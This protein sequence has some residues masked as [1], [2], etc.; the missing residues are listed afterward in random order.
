MHVNARMRTKTDLNECEH[1]LK[2][3]LDRSEYELSLQDRISLK[4]TFIASVS[5]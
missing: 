3:N 2:V 4:P 1:I 5:P